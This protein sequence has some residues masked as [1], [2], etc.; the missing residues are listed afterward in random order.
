MVQFVVFARPFCPLL[1]RQVRSLPLLLGFGS[2]GITFAF[3]FCAGPK[4]GFVSVSAHILLGTGRYYA[5][6]WLG[7]RQ[8]APYAVMGC[9]AS[10][11]RRVDDHCDSCA[12]TGAVVGVAEGVNAL[13]PCFPSGC[14]VLELYPG[15]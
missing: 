10:R 4:E 14:E 12:V 9:C 5:G 15:E 6:G 7:V 2:A 1:V 3:A 13:P 8:G 11:K